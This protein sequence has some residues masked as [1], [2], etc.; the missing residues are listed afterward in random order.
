MCVKKKVLFIYG[1]RPEIIKLSP[2]INC[3]KKCSDFNT[4]VIHSGQHN[5][6]TRD[7]ELLFNI[8]PDYRLETMQKGQSINV[9]LSKLIFEI[10]L[11]LLKIKPDIVF[12][13]GDTSTVLATSICCFNLNVKIAHIEAGLRSFDFENPF[14]EEYNRVIT[15]IATTLHLCPT[16]L[17]KENIEKSTKRSSNIF[18]TGNTCVDTV[19]L[20][21]NKLIDSVSDKKIILVTCHRREN[22]NIGIKTLLKSIKNLLEFRDDIIFIWPLHP[23]PQIQTIINEVGFK[24]DKLNI[25]PPL[26][27]LDLLQ[28]IKNSYLIWTDSGGI[29][30]EAPFFKK[31]ILILRKTTERPEVVHTG[32]AILT[33]INECT[34]VKETVKL[35][36]NESHYNTMIQ[37][38]NPFGDGYA[39]E[40]ILGITQSYL[41]QYA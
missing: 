6:L 5:E 28:T 9:T 13:Q 40:R 33:D 30:E 31:P 19:R 26:T 18:V 7:F 2:V 14:P 29:Q 39:S 15:T 4:T 17:S 1:T 21:S 36:D 20:F 23:N 37:G 38:T 32:F 3:F 27:Y 16:S 25:C 34:I 11:K 8:E 12:I 22:H 35:L 41:L 24:S 10:N